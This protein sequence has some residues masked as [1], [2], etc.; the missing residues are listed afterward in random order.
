[1]TSVEERLAVISLKVICLACY[2]VGL[3]TKHY[4]TSQKISLRFPRSNDIDS[5][6]FCLNFWEKLQLWHNRMLCMF[7]NDAGIFFRFLSIC[8]NVLH[9][10]QMLLF[11][12]MF[13]DCCNEC[14][15]TIEQ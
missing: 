14:G 9:S 10:F 7:N 2:L 12:L 13:Y 6:N 15:L 1:M 3:K 8:T 4:R 11:I 5:Q